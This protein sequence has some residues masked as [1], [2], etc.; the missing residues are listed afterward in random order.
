[1]REEKK[2]PIERKKP[3]SVVIGKVTLADATIEMAPNKPGRLPLTL[4]I[5]S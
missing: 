5:H 4:K 3:S 2:P 1:V